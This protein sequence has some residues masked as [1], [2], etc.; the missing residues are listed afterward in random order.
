MGFDF[1]YLPQVPFAMAED[2][3]VHLMNIRPDW[4]HVLK[5]DVSLRG[6]Q[7]VDGLVPHF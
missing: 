1:P 3:D 6:V 2:V 5:A 4:T 7:K